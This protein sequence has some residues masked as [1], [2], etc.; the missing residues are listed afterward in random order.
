[1]AHIEFEDLLKERDVLA[2]GRGKGSTKVTSSS[3]ESLL[4]ARY[5]KTSLRTL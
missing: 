1:M 5:E 4:F 3:S 2:D